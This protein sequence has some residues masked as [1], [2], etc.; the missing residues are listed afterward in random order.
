VLPLLA[1]A[2]L[3]LTE[4]PA[5]AHVEL[6][7]PNGGES[8]T[9]GSNFTI[10]W[11]P[12]VAMHDTLNWD[13]WYA[14]S[15]ASGPWIVIGEDLPPGSLVVGSSHSYAWTV[16]NITDASVWLRVRQ[17]ND[18]DPNYEDVSDGSFSITAANLTG[19][20]NHD[21]TVDAADYTVWR[22]VLGH[23]GAGLDADGNNNGQIDVGD[24]TTWKLHYGES[25]SSGGSFAAVPE[26]ASLLLLTVA[27]VIAGI[28]NRRTIR[29]WRLRAF[30]R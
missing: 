28:E 16:P 18:V 15:T 14:T 11:Q 10:A 17:D 21:D 3:L 25:L 4:H 13:L 9:G 7:A 23:P 5:W 2:L 27:A 1:A 6:D 29:S 12:A 26:P 30:A 19:D 22:N 20:Y 8:L 24:Y